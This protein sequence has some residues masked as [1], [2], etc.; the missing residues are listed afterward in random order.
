MEIFEIFEIL[1]R[2]AQKRATRLLFATTGEKGGH[3]E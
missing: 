2:V 1:M 3:D